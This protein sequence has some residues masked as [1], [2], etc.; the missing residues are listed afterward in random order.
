MALSEKGQQR[1]LARSVDHRIHEARKGIA[2]AGAPHPGGNEPAAEDDPELRLGAP[3]MTDHRENRQRLA[4]IVQRKTD[5]RD[6][7]LFHDFRKPI[8]EPEIEGIG[9]GRRGGAKQVGAP[10]GRERAGL[11]IG[12]AQANAERFC[13]HCEE[14]VQIRHRPS[15]AIGIRVESPRPE[16]CEVLLLVPCRP[17]R[18]GVASAIRVT[19]CRCQEGELSLQVGVPKTAG[20]AVTPER[21]REPRRPARRLTGLR[22]RR[23]DEDDPLR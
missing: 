22:R 14:A 16:R 1:D 11:I 17:P 19:G 21:P 2:P 13:R 6:G 23:V 18:P 12:E 9:I 20:N 10:D 5:V 4:E 8:P 3:D 15:V 7:C